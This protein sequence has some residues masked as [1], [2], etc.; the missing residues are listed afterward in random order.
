MKSIIDG[1]SIKLD[2]LFGYPIHL[3]EVKQGLVT[4]CFFIKPL[5]STS[6]DM[7]DNRKYRTYG[8][9]IIF[10]PNDEEPITSQFPEI[11]DKLFDN[12]DSIQLSDG[13]ILYTF[14]RTIEADEVLEFTVRFKV[15]LNKE[16]EAEPLLEHLEMSVI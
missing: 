13:T 2:D 6:K 10:V 15:Y 14:D 8:F 7:I 4:P 9:V 16:K 12:F 1:I 11:V 5:L 3:D